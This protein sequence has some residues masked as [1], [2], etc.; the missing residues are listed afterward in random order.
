MKLYQLR[1]W[2][3]GELESLADTYEL[4]ADEARE[5]LIEFLEEGQ[6]VCEDLTEKEIRIVL[7]WL[8]TSSRDGR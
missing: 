4:S 1:Q 3:Q 5:S 6:P 2:L 8:Y 7:E